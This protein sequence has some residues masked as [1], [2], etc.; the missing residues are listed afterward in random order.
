MTGFGTATNQRSGWNRL[1]ETRHRL[2]S[3]THFIPTIPILVEERICVQLSYFV[4]FV[5]RDMYHQQDQKSSTVVL[6]VIPPHYNIHH[7]GQPSPPQSPNT[8]QYSK[9]NSFFYNWKCG[10][11]T[12]KYVASN[13]LTETCVRPSTYVV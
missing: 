6:D 2:S 10:N 1:P 9:G 8:T 5:W 3:S 12:R 4:L 11:E 13:L 7:H